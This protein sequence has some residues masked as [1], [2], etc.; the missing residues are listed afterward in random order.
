MRAT[1]A[2]LETNAPHVLQKSS[3]ENM[4]LVGDD[5]HAFRDKRLED[6]SR[7]SLNICFFLLSL[8]I[9]LFSRE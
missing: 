2:I 8:Y 9:A 5:R 7:Y 3:F 4:S 1:Q 6:M